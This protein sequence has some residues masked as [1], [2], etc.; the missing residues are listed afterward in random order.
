MCFLLHFLKKGDCIHLTSIVL[1]KVEYSAVDVLIIPSFIL[2]ISLMLEMIN[3]YFLSRHYLLGN[4]NTFHY[5][6]QLNS[7]FSF[8]RAK[9]PYKL[10][11]QCKDK[12]FLPISFILSVNIRLANAYQQMINHSLRTLR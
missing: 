2:S 3:A 10:I 7:K 4:Y 9:N 6:V 12:I 1:R 5:C 11:T 8:S